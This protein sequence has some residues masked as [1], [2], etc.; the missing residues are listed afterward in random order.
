MIS[1]RSFAACLVLGLAAC[2]WV[3]LNESGKGVT[4]VRAAEVKDCER[5]GPVSAEVLYRV[6]FINRSQTKV[7]S[8]I[9]T[10]ARN[11]AGKLEGN[12]IVP[13]SPIER[14]SQTFDVYRCK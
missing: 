11:L 14:G 4:V 3:K 1:L 10:L 5:V 7:A 12:R 13:T 8:E 2:T 9:Q 6:L